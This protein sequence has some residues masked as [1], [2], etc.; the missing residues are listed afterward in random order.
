MLISRATEHFDERMSRRK[1]WTRS[2][3][4]GCGTDL[5]AYEAPSICPSILR[6]PILCIGLYW[7]SLYCTGFIAATWSSEISVRLSIVLDTA[8]MQVVNHP[9]HSILMQC[10]TCALQKKV[11]ACKLLHISRHKLYIAP[12]QSNTGEKFISHIQEERCTVRTIWPEEMESHCEFCDGSQYWM[13]F[14]FHRTIFLNYG[15]FET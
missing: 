1:H 9:D 10:F 11:T 3:S 5:A 14:Q 4:T 13:I 15:C 2:A 6:R 7:V 12:F 8:Q